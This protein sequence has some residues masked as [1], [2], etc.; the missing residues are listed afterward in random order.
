MRRLS[1]LLLLLGCCA[2]P[3]CGSGDDDGG[4]DNPGADG[5]VAA[6]A[7]SGPDFPAGTPHIRISQRSIEAA[8]IDT[9]ISAAWWASPPPDPYHQVAE[10][11]PC[12][13]T[14]TAPTGCDDLCD[15]VCIDGA[16]E[17]FPATRTAGRLTVTG[18]EQTVEVAPIDG[19]YSF[20]QTSPLFA[21][22]DLVAIAAAGDDL[23]AFEVETRAVADLAA[24]GIDELV[25]TPGEEL[26]VSWQPADP[27]SR[28][29]L[30]L[31]SDQHGQFS[32]T[33]IECDVADDAG[34][35]AIPGTMIEQF[36]ATPGQCGECPVQSLIRYSRGSAT[37]GEQ[38]VIVEYASTVSFY[39]YP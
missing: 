31:D 26:R 22:G 7:S 34:S 23:P 20:Y 2:A 17:P 10:S 15:G 28:I 8:S 14:Q 19:W 35:I 27:D 5:S 18:G 29:R 12:V 9:G 13:L 38:T 36:W 6:D 32:P 30:R 37:A 16:C 1:R 21:P 33:V 24:P 3:G 39:P 4:D 11:G 25:M